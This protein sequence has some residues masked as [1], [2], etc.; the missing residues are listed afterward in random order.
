MSTTTENLVEEKKREALSKVD[1]LKSLVIERVHKGHYK[2]MN[3]NTK[4]YLSIFNNEDIGI[5]L[6]NFANARNYALNGYVKTNC[7]FP[8]E[9]QKLLIQ[10]CTFIH[11]YAFKKNEYTMPIPTNIFGEKIQ[12]SMSRMIEELEYMGCIECIQPISRFFK[13]DPDH[14]I[15]CSYKID[16]V[17][18][19]FCYEVVER[20]NDLR[21]MPKRIAESSYSSLTP[22]SSMLIDTLAT[23]RY[24]SSNFLSSSLSPSYNAERGGQFRNKHFGSNTAERNKQLHLNKLRKTLGISTHETIMKQLY[25]LVG[26]KCAIKI[27]A[28]WSDQDIEYALNIKFNV[29][30]LKELHELVDIQGNETQIRWNISRDKTGT[31]TKIGIRPTNRLCKTYNEEH[32]E[33]AHILGQTT[34]RHEVLNLLGAYHHIDLKCSIYNINSAMRTN[35]FLNKDY[36]QEVANLLNKERSIVKKLFMKSNFGTMVEGHLNGK[37]RDIELCYDIDGKSIKSGITYKQMQNAM[38]ESGLAICGTDTSIFYW[39]D[40][41]YTHVQRILLEEGIK[42]TRVYDSFYTDKEVS[43]EHIVELINEVLNDSTLWC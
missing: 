11:T 14:S 43:T 17:F 31:I 1:Y 22:I 18:K 41:V 3:T 26:I 27:P 9:K 7:R 19:N 28:L 13:Y 30:E 8:I 5:A 15:A 35:K 24:S 37:N 36:Y 32:D 6:N 33:K 2:P 39:E 25:P 38:I 40:V 42:S 23:I 20:V 29:Q 16:M 4:H 21:E 34:R 10:L 12:T